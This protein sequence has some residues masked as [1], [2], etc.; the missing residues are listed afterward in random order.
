MRNRVRIHTHSS[1]RDKRPEKTFFVGTVL[2]LEERTFL[3]KT[4]RGRGRGT[5]TSEKAGC[6]GGKALDSLDKRSMHGMVRES[7][8][9]PKDK[10]PS[11]SL[12]FWYDM[13]LST[14]RQQYL[15]R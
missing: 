9:T 5:N 2:R 8:S 4:Q 13:S 1:E 15:W 10:N 3:L 7:E 11:K 12:G 6:T 14:V